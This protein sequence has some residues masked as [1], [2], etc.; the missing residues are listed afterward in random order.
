MACVMEWGHLILLDRWADEKPGA[1]PS[2]Q[3]GQFSSDDIPQRYLAE[4]NETCNCVL[5][6]VEVLLH[7]PSTRCEVVNL[8]ASESA[9]GSGQDPSSSQPCRN[10]KNYRPALYS[11]TLELSLELFVDPE[12]MV[13][14]LQK[15]FGTIIFI[16][17]PGAPE[18][19]QVACVCDPEDFCGRH[20]PAGGG[21]E[22]ELSSY[23]K[24]S[25]SSS[26]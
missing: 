18:G 21:F 2:Q 6:R 3:R 12:H 23:R 15:L 24:L 16:F 19:V 4:E 8:P 14:Q 1:S 5:G 7:A 25:R 26:M 20:F 17:Y 11:S 13:I 22:I 9:A 10:F